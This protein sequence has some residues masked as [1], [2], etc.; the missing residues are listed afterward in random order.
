LFRESPNG[1]RA[2]ASRPPHAFSAPSAR[3]TLNKS[4]LARQ[5]LSTPR[6]VGPAAPQTALPDRKTAPTPPG[7]RSLSILLHPSAR[8]GH[9]DDR[10]GT[11]RRSIPV[12]SPT[13]LREM[14]SPSHS[15]RESARE[16]KRSGQ[17]GG[18]TRHTPRCARRPFR[19]IRFKGRKS[20]ARDVARVLSRPCR[21]P[22]PTL[23]EQPCGLDALRQ[24]VRGGGAATVPSPRVAPCARLRG[25]FV[26]SEE[27]R[28]RP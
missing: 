25:N 11:S 18:Q 19:S 14:A 3:P 4:T 27:S 1:P 8:T 17:V 10:A 15:S 20:R 26:G 12:E 21:L 28:R 13:A 22:D 7:T 5:Y 23:R 9:W 16:R 2:G 6:R 24:L